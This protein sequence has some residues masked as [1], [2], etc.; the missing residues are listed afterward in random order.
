MVNADGQVKW[1]VADSPNQTKLMLYGFV[2]ADEVGHPITPEKIAK[3]YA[4]I[5]KE[6]GIDEKIKLPIV[7]GF[8][9]TATINGG[10]A[11]VTLE[12]GETND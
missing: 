9:G 1:T 4:D 5:R 8:L 10:A 12:D 2:L 11:Y 3:H 7:G 6:S